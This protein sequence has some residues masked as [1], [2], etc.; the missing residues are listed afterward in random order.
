MSF[1]IKNS[2]IY[3]WSIAYLLV[4]FFFSE[5]I[6]IYG[7]YIWGVYLVLALPYYAH[8]DKYLMICFLLST[9]SDY[10]SGVGEGIMGL[11][12]ILLILMVINVFLKKKKF[13]IRGQL[14][15]CLLIVCI[16]ISF[17]NSPFNYINGAYSMSYVIFVCIMIMG[18]VNVE[19][20][21]LSEF[22]PAL[23][24]IIILFFLV[25]L[26][27]HGNLFGIMLSI[28]P[29][30]NHNAFGRCLAQLSTI[31]A[32]KIFSS[33]KKSI[34]YILPWII[35]ILMT[36]MTG[37]RN[38]FLAEAVSIIFIYLIIQRQKNQRISKLVTTIIVVSIFLVIAY[39]VLPYMGVNLERYNFVELVESGGTN[40]TT[41]WKLLIPVLL[42][43]YLLFGY[44]PGY[45][46]SANIVSGLV[47]R[48]YTNTHNVFI[49]VWGEL[50][51]IGLMCF[52]GLVITSFYKVYSKL[53]NNTTVL[54]VIALYIDIFVNGLGEATFAGMNLWIV[55]ALCYCVKETCEIND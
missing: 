44:G 39:M 51:I 37:S 4:V 48:A 45:Y 42:S 35:T 22:L 1:S 6:T 26:L 18:L 32:V 49:E 14:F 31:L 47:N 9:L 27:V 53:K 2:R 7:A 29:S 28:N 50:G 23:T 12:T 19:N 40:R 21:T 43:E 36:L 24:V 41:I 33:N 52:V 17:F 13:T 8:I 11:Y 46:C 16:W 5:I 54:Y 55:I 20:D 3:L 34:I 25:V 10:F 15:P 38:A 30:I